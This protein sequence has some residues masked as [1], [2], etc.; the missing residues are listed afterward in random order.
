MDPGPMGA[1]ID[2]GLFENKVNRI[3]RGISRLRK[4]WLSS[5]ECMVDALASR[6]DEGRSIAAISFGEPLSGP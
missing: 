3:K 4:Q 2:R 5:E 1:E 6:A